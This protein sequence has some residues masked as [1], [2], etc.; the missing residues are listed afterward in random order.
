MKKTINLILLFL[1]FLLSVHAVNDTPWVRQQNRRTNSFIREN[2][3]SDEIFKAIL[4]KPYGERRA[5]RIQTPQDQK[6]ER[7]LGRIQADDTFTFT[8]NQQ[9]TPFATIAL[10]DLFK[11]GLPTTSLRFGKISRDQKLAILA[12]SRKSNESTYELYEYNFDTSAL[13]LL[14]EEVN[15]LETW[16]DPNAEKDTFTY[17]TLQRDGLQRRV[18]KEFGNPLFKIE[19]SNTFVKRDKWSRLTT[20]RWLGGDLYLHHNETFPNGNLVLGQN[21][22]IGLLP[23]NSKGVILEAIIYLN[24]LVLT[25]TWG[26]LFWIELYDQNLQKIKSYNLPNGVRLDR[27]SLEGQYL[28]GNYNPI[29]QKSYKVFINLDR[30]EILQEGNQI[31]MS[32]ALLSQIDPFIE[33]EGKYKNYSVQRFNATAPDGEEI[34]YISIELKDENTG[35]ERPTLINVYGGFTINFLQHYKINQEDN[36]FIN[37]GGRVVFADLRGGTSKG[38]E[39]YFKGL[40]EKRLDTAMD[41]VSLSKDL[42]RRGMA[43]AKGIISTGASNGGFVVALAAMLSPEDFGLVIPVNGVLN[44]SQ[45]DTLDLRYHGWGSELTSLHDGQSLEDLALQ[46][47]II[48]GKKLIQEGRKL[49]QFLVIS[50]LN[51]ERV[52]PLHSQS[53]V[54]ELILAAEEMNSPELASGLYFYGVKNNGH[55]VSTNPQIYK[56][57]QARIYAYIFGFL[58]P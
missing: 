40:K 43:K 31:P 29:Y 1:P 50:S 42:Q 14:E 58:N 37:K 51:D 41:L 19:D 56:G 44:F 54:K 38:P 5:E 4:S 34:P 30:G 27:L 12:F 20:V 57:L 23:S 32:F 18:T 28:I 8:S 13:T 25:R 48:L 45:K 3:F 7:I 22:T 39:W 49:S 6:I 11:N 46:D 52:H 2:S 21:P 47:P 26:N 10:R 15:F 55:Y 24:Q 36:L 17:Y 33:Y 35:K 53:F 9:D 16:D